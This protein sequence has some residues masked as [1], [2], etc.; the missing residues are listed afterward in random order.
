VLSWSV[1]D[2]YGFG[3]AGFFFLKR[4][5]AP[6]LASFR[7][8]EDG[9][10]ELWITNDTLQP[11]EETVTVRLGSF[12]GDSEWEVSL[13]VSVPA[14]TSS[15]V[16]T[17][18]ADKVSGSADRYIAVS[19]GTNLF[20]QNRSFFSAIKDLRRSAGEVAVATT[21]IDAN[22][23]EVRLAAKNFAYFVHLAVPHEATT[24]SDNYFD[25]LPGEERLITVW[26]SVAEI[27][28]DM[29]A[30]RWR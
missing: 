22:T 20:P 21:A 26:N 13:P 4:V 2:Y 25:L 10:V 30:V 3:K 16:H 9:S 18:K 7:L 1:L 11:V 23:V 8:L 29:V 27:L 19:S 12:S 17:W 28:P 15:S 14:I 5:Y 6:V 24:Y